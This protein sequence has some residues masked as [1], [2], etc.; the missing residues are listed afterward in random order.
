NTPVFI[1][2]QHL[3]IIGRVSMDMIAIDLTKSPEASLGDKA[4]LWGLN[5]PVETIAKAAGTIPY[6]LICQISTRVPKTII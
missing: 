3:P 5:L 2:G 6:E 4:E 1:K